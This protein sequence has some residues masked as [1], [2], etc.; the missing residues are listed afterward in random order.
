MKEKIRLWMKETAFHPF[1]FSVFPVLFLYVR[2]IGKGFFWEAF[3]IGAALIVLVA[4]F[5]LLVSLRVKQRDKSAVVAS[6]FIVLFFT[7]GHAVSA[8]SS[9]LERLGLVDQSSLLAEGQ[10]FR[11]VCLGVWGGIFVAI[12]WF[13]A[14]SGSDFSSLTNILN[15]VSLTLMLSVGANLVATEW[16][17]ISSR[18]PL[19]GNTKGGSPASSDTAVSQ[20]RNRLAEFT[21]WWERKLPASGNVAASTGSLP[22]IYY[23]V[24]DAYA[25]DDI[26]KD[27][28]RFDNSDFLSYLAEKGFYVANES[29]ANYPQ[30]SLSLSSSLNLM[31]L[32]P[33]VDRLGT[34]TDDREPL[35]MMIKHNRVIKHLR[36]AGYTVLAFESGYEDSA[37]RGADV[38]MTPPNLWDLSG[39]QEALITLT[40]LSI[41][42]KTWFDFRRDRVEYA[43]DHMA[44]ATQFDGPTFT[45]VHVLV[46][47]WPFIFDEDGRS[48]QPPKS[49]GMRAD[50]AY[51][52]FT[53]L[54]RD[55]LV[56]VNKQMQMTIDEILSQSSDPPI[57]VL[58]ADH[59]PDAKLDYGAWRI[60]DTYLP[61]RMS[62]LNAYYFPGKDYAA[63]YESITPVNT[64][65]VILDSY[66]GTD[67][68][69]LEDRSY[70]ASWNRPY[71]FT[72]VTSEVLPVNEK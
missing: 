19:G 72:D 51:E 32:D 27:I 13:I 60:E 20:D 44:D 69:L 71:S 6:G 40:P 25:R 39:F 54:Y 63:L 50:Y 8:A 2:N 9:M 38:Y 24:V 10:V 4:L 36:D 28:Y 21:D 12:L 41:F 68:G 14:R 70:F 62:I 55:Q 64:F 67:Y 47:H 57:I 61:E 58:Q 11:L 45:F 33:V 49:I 26:L 43:F 30:T 22:D 23:I 35:R 34:E 37:L 3:G 65:R 7:Y 59:G 66:F 1:A 46:P 17:S 53:E 15:I 18:F 29:V 48:I 31:Y 5:W 16:G 52:A 42:E 56:F